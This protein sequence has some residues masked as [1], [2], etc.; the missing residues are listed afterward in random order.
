MQVVCNVVVVALRKIQMQEVASVM[1]AF[2]SSLRYRFKEYA[3]PW[4][5]NKRYKRKK[6][7]SPAFVEPYVR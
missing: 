7:Y 1:C 5:M 2:V 3:I 4:N 6:F